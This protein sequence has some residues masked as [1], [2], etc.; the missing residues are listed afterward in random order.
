MKEDELEKLIQKYKEGDSTLS[1][2]KVLFNNSKKSESSLELWF[3]FVNE[4]KTEIP[5]DLNS[6][7]WQSF[8]NKKANKRR[9]LV[10][11]MGVAAS[12]LILGIF[13]I[14]NFEQKE[15][16]YSEKERLLNQALAMFESNEGEE[17]QHTVFYENDLIIIYMTTE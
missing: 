4:N 3:T 9:F 12:I 15:Q 13:L 16:S 2:E 5:K 7:L 17:N 1:E 6:R 14:G 10:K 8:Q 11:I